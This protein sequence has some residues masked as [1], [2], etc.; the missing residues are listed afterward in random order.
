MYDASDFTEE[1][2][3]SMRTSLPD[4]SEISNGSSDTMA[5]RNMAKRPP[6]LEK[7]VEMFKRQN[8]SLRVEVYYLKTRLREAGITCECPDP[9][10]YQLDTA[11]LNG[12][13][14]VKSVEFDLTTKQV[15]KLDTIYKIRSTALQHELEQERCKSQAAENLRLKCQKLEQDKISLL[16]FLEKLKNENSLLRNAMAAM[17]ESSESDSSSI[18][19]TMNKKDKGVLQRSLTQIHQQSLLKKK[20]QNQCFQEA[21]PV[22]ITV[23]ASTMTSAIASPGN[24]FK[25]DNI[26][27]LEERCLQAESRV[28]ELQCILNQ[29]PPGLLQSVFPA[30]NVGSV[31]SSKEE[32]QGSN[33]SNDNKDAELLSTECRKC[34]RYEQVLAAIRKKFAGKQGTRQD[35]SSANHSEAD[36]PHLNAINDSI[37]RWLQKSLCAQEDREAF[38]QKFRCIYSANSQLCKR[39]QESASILREVCAKLADTG[40]DISDLTELHLLQD[41]ML[42][43]LNAT[44]SLITAIETSI[45][46]AMPTNDEVSRLQEQ[47]AHVQTLLEQ[48]DSHIEVPQPTNPCC[49]DA[50]VQCKTTFDAENFQWPALV[51]SVFPGLDTITE[52]FIFFLDVLTDVIGG[53]CN[54]DDKERLILNLCDHFRE[55]LLPCF[56][57]L[58]TGE[59]S[60]V[61][62]NGGSKRTEQENAE[63]DSTS[64]SERIVDDSLDK[65]KDSFPETAGTTALNRSLLRKSHQQCCLAPDVMFSLCK[66]IRTALELLGCIQKS[67]NAAEVKEHFRQLTMTI[68]L[69]VDFSQ[70]LFFHMRSAGKEEVT[71]IEEACSEN[72]TGAALCSAQL[73]QSNSHLEVEEMSLS[74]LV[75]QTDIV[76]SSSPFMLNASAAGRIQYLLASNQRCSEQMEAVV[77][78]MNQ[79]NREMEMAIL[80]RKKMSQELQ[81]LRDREMRL[82]EENDKAK[83]K[84]D[85]L[86]EELTLLKRQVNCNEEGTLTGCSKGEFLVNRSDSSAEVR[87]TAR[88]VGTTTIAEITEGTLYVDNSSKPARSQPEAAKNAKLLAEVELYKEELKKAKDELNFTLKSLQEEQDTKTAAARE[89][90]EDIKR[91]ADLFRKLKHKSRH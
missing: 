44:E 77:D 72:V 52:Q 6:G 61:T 36:E 1:R 68:Q 20:P 70:K 67:Q 43:K 9:R 22:K 89:I 39:M 26:E 25:T 64:V 86:E 78:K 3:Y 37:N 7:Q 74:R 84:I 49:N 75:H 59:T 24:T 35:D 60:G 90:T 12:I 47:L 85:L 54:E 65:M 32:V 23:E 33:S 18:T 11:T 66:E 63:S 16:S 5:I 4:L 62:E 29:R 73:L 40:V 15:E 55:N 21:Q 69:C 51:L 30:I 28:E 34:R 19:N 88:K 41:D 58:E 48:R 71:I 8:L 87:N 76:T 10:E 53:D 91:T 27:R 83:E 45:S 14:P 79:N 31:F 42:L 82:I 81:L 2:R 80:K 57:A 38:K 17:N 13:V 46:L 50:A 56:Q